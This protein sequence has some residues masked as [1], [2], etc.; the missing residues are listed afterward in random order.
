METLSKIQAE[1]LVNMYDYND[2]VVLGP[3]VCLGFE[4]ENVHNWAREHP[5]EA[6]DLRD[7]EDA[8]FEDEEGELSGETTIIVDE[9]FSVDDQDNNDAANSN[10]IVAP[11]DTSVEKP[12]NPPAP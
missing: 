4:A 3:H 2:L 8:E 7:R 6:M 1:F 11:E 5:K 12:S 9:G 10:P